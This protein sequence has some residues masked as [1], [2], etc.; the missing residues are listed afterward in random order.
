MIKDLLRKLLKALLWLL[1]Y[2]N[3][4][5][6]PEP[7]T[8]YYRFSQFLTNKRFSRRERSGKPRRVIR[9]YYKEPAVVQ[10]K[11]AEY[12]LSWFFYHKEEVIQ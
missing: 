1:G 8:R 4:N 11:P 3:K 6:I 9:R 5:I 7:I 12:V 2:R 10:F